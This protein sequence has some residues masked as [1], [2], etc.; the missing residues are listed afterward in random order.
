MEDLTMWS[1]VLPIDGIQAIMIDL[2]GHGKSTLH[3]I[4]QPSI[5]FLAHQV[6]DLVKEHQWF[7]AQIV[8][9]SL[10]GYVGLELMEINPYFEHLT[11]L[12]SHPWADSDQKK[13]DRNRVIDLVKQHADLFIREAIPH[14]FHDS[15]KHENK[16][17]HYIAIAKQMSSA[18]IAWNAKAMRD[19]G[20]KIELM[21]QNPSKFTCVQ[22]EMDALIPKSQVMKFCQENQINYL[23]LDNCGHMGQEESPEILKQMLSLIVSNPLQNKLLEW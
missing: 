4:G 18:A 2:N 11:L 3:G 10:G 15:S 19:R 13:N 9:H 7:S 14:L 12:H 5:T 21:E 8:G 1:N 17:T 23:E 6:M 16:I 20:D 22:G